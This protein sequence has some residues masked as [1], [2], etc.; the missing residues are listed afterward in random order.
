M[1]LVDSDPLKC[2]QKL[3]TVQLLGFSRLRKKLVKLPNKR[4]IYD[5]IKQCTKKVD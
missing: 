1:V 2:R 4:V 5:L 3:K